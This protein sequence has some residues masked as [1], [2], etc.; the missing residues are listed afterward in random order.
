[1][2]SSQ[3]STFKQNVYGQPPDNPLVRYDLKPSPRGNGEFDIKSYIEQCR[4]ALMFA[5]SELKE[6]KKQI[7][8]YRS[9]IGSMQRNL[10]TLNNDNLKQMVPVVQHDTEFFNQAMSAQR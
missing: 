9:E 1:M 2:N 3:N 4:N 10:E 5:Q 7:E 6:Q 8:T